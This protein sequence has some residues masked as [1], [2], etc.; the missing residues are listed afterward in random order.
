MD[1]SATKVVGE[2]CLLSDYSF[3]KPLL[4]AISR[5][6]GNSPCRTRTNCVVF[7]FLSARCHAKCFAQ[8]PGRS[9]RRIARCRCFLG[10]RSR[11]SA[12]P[13]SGRRCRCGACRAS[14]CRGTPPSSRVARRGSKAKGQRHQCCQGVEAGFQQGRRD[15]EIRFQGRPG[16]RALIARCRGQAHQKGRPPHDAILGQIKRTAS[17]SVYDAE[18]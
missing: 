8:R 16:P 14:R 3:A 4:C 5:R 13:A 7:C 11:S 18:S 9:G 15:V 2:V 10:S 1:K 17:A 12:W 6:Y